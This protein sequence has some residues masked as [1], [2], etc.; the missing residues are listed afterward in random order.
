LSN[1]TRTWWAANTSTARRTAVGT[2]AL[3]LGLSAISYF[4]WVSPSNPVTTTIAAV[5][6]EQIHT[7]AL[8]TERAEL[9][10]RVVA[11]KSD[12]ATSTSASDDLEAAKSRR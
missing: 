3:G 12:L 1:I 9:L 7:E 11:L 6:Q 4:V 2:V 10:D 5:S 8:T